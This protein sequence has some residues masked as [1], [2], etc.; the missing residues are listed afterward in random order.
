MVLSLS[1]SNAWI[2]VFNFMYF[3][4]FLFGFFN[5]LF[6][7]LIFHLLSILLFANFSLEGSYFGFCWFVFHILLA[8]CWQGLTLILF[9]V[10]CAC[11]FVCFF[12]CFFEQCPCSQWWGPWRALLC[13]YSAYFVRAVVRNRMLFGFLSCFT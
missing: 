9:F 12:W 1:C 6:W 10:L 13:F 8:S 2:L 11:M 4:S 7:P 5:A 3:G